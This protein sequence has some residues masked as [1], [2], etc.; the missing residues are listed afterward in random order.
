VGRRPER[1][2]RVASWIGALAPRLCAPL[3]IELAHVAGLRRAERHL[4]R[5]LAAG[6]VRRA[7]AELVWDEPLRRAILDR[8][9]WQAAPW[10]ARARVTI[11]R[12][13]E[14]R[15]DDGDL[16]DAIDQWLAVGDRTRALRALRMAAPDALER[17]REASLLE[18]C[19]RLHECAGPSPCW[20]TYLLACAL[21]RRGDLLRA[22][23]AF[24]SVATRRSARS[25]GW[26]PEAAELHASAGLLELRLGYVARA[27]LSRDAARLASKPRGSARLAHLEARLALG[28][29]ALDE[30]EQRFDRAALLATRSQD[31]AERAEAISGLGVI[32]MRRG[33]PRDA[34]EHY[35]R[36]LAESRM[37]PG[38]ARTARILANH[39]GARSMLGDWSAAAQ[40]EQAAELRESI[41][42]LA[43]AANSIAGAAL[44][45]EGA[46]EAERALEMLDL[47]K[48][49]ADS[50]GDPALGF[51]IRLLRSCVAARL[52]DVTTAR[53]ELRAADVL[54]RR[55]EQLDPLLEGLLDETYAELALAGR[56]AGACARAARRA[57]GVYRAQRAAYLAARVH[58]LLA[59]NAERLGRVAVA[60][61][62]L[63][64]VASRVVPSGARL[65]TAWASRRVL[66]L[67]LE[68]STEEVRHVAAHL[69]AR[70]EAPLPTA[71]RND[72]FRV[73]DRRGAHR[74][75][76]REVARLRANPPDAFVDLPRS[77]VVA[78]GV[79][80]PFAARRI[81]VPLL[82]ALLT[83]ADTLDAE[84]L[85]REVWG[86][87]RF[88]AAAR[89]RLKVAVSRARSLLGHDAIETHS[90]RSPSGALVTRYGLS[91]TIE[92]TVLQGKSGSQTSDAET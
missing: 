9:T 65:S 49:N 46:G 62:H 52:G 53:A 51:E 15:G 32:A 56:D 37:V 44:A 83:A 28:R 63:R 60:L 8:H 71:R 45:R 82:L 69:L 55:L 75:T 73:I 39:A 64:G 26:V 16:A 85:H 76:E 17:G 7:G 21:E 10:L 90:S 48:R 47:A 78:R 80:H 14:R 57:L 87:D 34:V 72:G 79:V 38:V 54:R 3:W 70:P 81:L 12:F 2:R 30:A 24:A 13:Y 35:R 36:A 84:S 33:R 77:E 66:E 27:E 89:T 6:W 22:A 42:D 88:D 58:L 68:S 86:I 19:E 50:G 11:A 43:G 20:L 4:E 29:G 18:V 59:R 41:G 61:A 74:R 91:R 40:F 25:P 1:E 67:G 31:S 92:L 5:W 23:T